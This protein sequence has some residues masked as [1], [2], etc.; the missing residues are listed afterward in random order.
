[1][2]EKIENRFLANLPIAIQIK[3]LVILSGIDCKPK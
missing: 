2:A 3:F 1:M